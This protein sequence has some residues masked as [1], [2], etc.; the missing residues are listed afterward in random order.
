M[1]VAWIVYGPIDQPTGGYIYDRILAQRGRDAGDEVVVVSLEPGSSADDLVA[2]LFAAEADA[3][4]GDAL[5]VREVAPA[6]ER[7]SA[8]GDAGGVVRPRARVLLVHHPK[9]WEKELGDD[10]REA[11]RM[12]EAR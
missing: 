2:R 4:V 9:S 3:I 10:E 8:S 5:C 7:L 12:A 11:Q 6:F 1:R